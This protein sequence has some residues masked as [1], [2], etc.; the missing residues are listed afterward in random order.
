MAMYALILSLLAPST[1]TS[2]QG[3]SHSLNMVIILNCLV[4]I[5][6]IIGCYSSYGKK[7][8]LLIVVSIYIQ[9]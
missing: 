2:T 4:T 3:I 8:C 7:K 1:G 6:A 9:M 5:I